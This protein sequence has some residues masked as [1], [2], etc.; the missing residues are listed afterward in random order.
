MPDIWTLGTTAVQIP[1]SA[2]SPTK[3]TNGGASDVGRNT[4]SAVVSTDNALAA[5]ASYTAEAPFWYVS[6]ASSKL[7]IER[8]ATATAGAFRS[9]DIWTHSGPP[10]SGTTYG[11][12]F[13]VDNGG[14]LLD[15]VNG[16]LYV[17]ENTAASPYWTPVSF[18][19]PGILGGIVNK[20][21]GNTAPLALTTAQTVGNGIRLFGL[22]VEE[23]DDS[24]FVGAVTG[25]TGSEINVLHVT[26]EAGKIAALGSQATIGTPASNGTMVVDIIY[27]DVADI[28]TSSVFLGF[29]GGTTADNMGPPISGATTVATFGVDVVFGWYSDSSM[30]DANGGFLV[31]E[32]ANLAGTQTGLVTTTDRAAAATYQQLRVEVHTDGR[33]V[34]F[35]NKA[36]AGIIPGATGAGAH[37][38]TVVAATP[39][40]A[41]SPLF[42]IENTTTV[43]RTANVKSFAHW[44]TR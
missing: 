13:G 44:A 16:N 9:P 26:N 34:F 21:I 22:G 42:Y 15:Q 40:T 5:G 25:V 8:Y 32:K 11:A 43:T 30:T 24:G 19:Q 2:E 37:D 23:A 39:S 1:A 12:P 41:L 4:T 10:K 31:C 14:L 35:A 6:A 36:Q 33:A 29:I 7:I 3:I 17:N 28:L 18:D 27:T 38:A 20:N